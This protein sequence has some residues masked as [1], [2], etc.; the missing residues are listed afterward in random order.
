MK[1]V[2]RG[3]SKRVRS[4][5][6]RVPQVPDAL[7]EKLRG[8]VGK[9]LSGLAGGAEAGNELRAL[10]DQARRSFAEQAAA[11]RARLNEERGAMQKSLDAMPALRRPARKRSR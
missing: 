7:S 10:L 9:A 11:G 2:C 4:G 8:R 5:N 6:Q 1:E 3:A